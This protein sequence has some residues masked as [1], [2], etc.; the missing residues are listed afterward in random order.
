MSEDKKKSL[1]AATRIVR[2]GRDK[3]ITGPFVNPPVVHASTVLFDS[4]DDMTHLRQRY[5]YGRRGTPTTEA[6]MTAIA[7]LD[8]A[9]GAIIAPS[10][11]AAASLALLSCLGAGDRILIV[12]TV[13]GPVRHLADTVLKRFGIEVTYYDPHLGAGIDRLFTANTRAVYVESPG[14]LTFEMQDLPA[15]AAVAHRHGA[16]VLADNTWATPLY[17]RPLEHGADLSIMAGTKYL[18]GHSDAMIGAVS[19][20]GQALHRLREAW[21]TFGTHVGPDDVYLT[22]RGM[23]TLAV[24]LERHQTSASRIAGWLA[25]RP[26]VARVLY[27]ALPSDPGHAL[28]KRDMTGASGLFG[29]VMRGWSEDQAAL[30]VD[31]L[32]LF[33][34]G[35]SWGGFESLAIVSHIKRQRTAT[36]WNAEGPLLRLNIGLED[37]A[38]LMADLESAFT[39]VADA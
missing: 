3:S 17:S 13:Y 37:P 16:T 10:G 28:W 6:L 12:D 23:R 35:A 33:G 22:L 2:A 15:I 4:V 18:V 26:E 30:F 19:A 32:Q 1:S 21:G 11:L 39:A 24:R 7:E 38:D 14:S 36:T 5:H 31:S 29:L 27:P 34:I 25:A 20:N 8:N 9:E